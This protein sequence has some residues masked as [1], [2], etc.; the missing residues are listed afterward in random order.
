MVKRH[1]LS[2]M[3]VY[4]NT[5][6]LYQQQDTQIF[7]YLR[8]STYNELHDTFVPD[9]VKTSVANENIISQTPLYLEFKLIIQK[10]K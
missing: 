3:W 5:F 8:V 6:Y 4:T 10:E 7:E 9:A 2:I 1:V